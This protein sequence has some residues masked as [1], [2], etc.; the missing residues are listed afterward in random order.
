MTNDETNQTVDTDFDGISFVD[1]SPG[2]VLSINTEGQI[3]YK[4][5]AG[6][7]ILE[8]WNCP[9]NQVTDE[10]KNYVTS[11]IE[12]DTPVKSELEFEDH[13]F[14]V[15]YI[16][17][18]DHRHV[19]ILGLDITERKAVEKTLRLTQYSVDH[20]GESIYWL[21][22]DAR[23]VY[24]NE[25]ACRKLG[26][27]YAEL[28]TLTAADIDI[29]FPVGQWDYYWQ[30]VKE[31]K[32]IKL[33]TMHKTKTGD[34]I[35]VSI[36][37]N[38]VSSE[39]V[40]YLC[41]FVTDMSE[42]KEKERKLQEAKDRFQTLTEQTSDWIWEL[43]TT[44]KYTYASPR[45]EPILG[46]KAEEMIGKNFLDTMPDWQA[47][48]CKRS[49]EYC[50][51]KHLP[52]ESLHNENIR[53]DGKKVILETSALPFFDKDN[54]LLGFRGIDR[55]IT[56]RK[57][58]EKRTKQLL[59]MLET[60]NRELKNFI[61]IVRHDIGNP[62]LSIE[63]FIK[64]LSRSMKSVQNLIVES[65]ID[66]DLR[67]QLN[68][69]VNDRILPG[70]DFIKKSIQEIDDLLEGLR[71]IS[72]IGHISLDIQQV[73]MN[74]L[75]SDL[76]VKLK[77][78][79]EEADAD[80]LLEYLPDCKGDAALIKQVFTNLIS[81]SIKYLSPERKGKVVITGKVQ[82]T[83]AIYSIKD[84]GI[85]ISRENRKKVFDIFFRADPFGTVRGDGLGLAIVQ[86]IIQSHEGSVWVD[87]EPGKGSTFHVALPAAE[88]S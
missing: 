10:L 15:E 33:E 50:V 72:T 61:S 39:G 78:A 83:T 74:Q 42:I 45:V 30:K 62:L 48:K 37:C 4:N 60:R 13:T 31:D 43:D 19:N 8:S 14:Y 27:S 73:D 68:T 55:D 79:I 26:Y 53:K 25:T 86:R 76:I 38:V 56:E 16:P 36:N 85:G 69:T 58:A 7:M 77:P 20:A 29:N 64:E 49:F 23:L 81:N 52:I 70:I 2:P 40:E 80:V 88:S 11:I 47:K 44:G 46:Y 75:V 51:E 65:D 21:T 67:I 59:S 84:N 35:P 17:S 12:N 9:E 82:D 18:R 41:C 87:S 66:T 34:L 63:T 3:I 71:H 32:S 28:L 1:E 57:E 22:S 6:N 54:N 5:Q 24:V